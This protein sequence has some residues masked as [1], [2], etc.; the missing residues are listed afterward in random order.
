MRKNIGYFEGTD[1]LLLT[2]L[3]MHGIDTLPIS[4]GVDNHG[5][6]VRYLTKA[7]EIEIVIGYFHKVIPLDE[8]KMTTE[9]MLFSC[10]AYEIP[11][12]LIV[13]EDLREKAP[14]AIGALPKGVQ[15]VTLDEAFDAVMKI[16]G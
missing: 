11:V 1:P 15:F 6:E 12:L 8:M 4:N 14:A 13:P 5:K 2:R 3:T 16:L 7:D 9:D 10:A